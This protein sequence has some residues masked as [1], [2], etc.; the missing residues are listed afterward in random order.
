MRVPHLFQR[1]QRAWT[2]GNRV[3]LLENGEQYYPAVFD[4]IAQAQHEV[5]IETFILVED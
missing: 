3:E 1:P 4:A 2:D 5:M